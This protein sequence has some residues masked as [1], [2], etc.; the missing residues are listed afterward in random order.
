MAELKAAV[1]AV[2][3]KTD[4]VPRARLAEQLVAVGQLAEFADIVPVSAVSS[5]HTARKLRG[6]APLGSSREL[7]HHTPLASCGASLRSAP[8]AS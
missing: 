6:L 8:R 5:P 3:T 2:V 1:V 7:S 4:L